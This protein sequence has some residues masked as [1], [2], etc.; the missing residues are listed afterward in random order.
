[1]R[2]GYRARKYKP[3]I[4]GPFDKRKVF[5]VPYELSLGLRARR[6]YLA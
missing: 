1:M 3:N 5:L 2:I 6:R 4:S